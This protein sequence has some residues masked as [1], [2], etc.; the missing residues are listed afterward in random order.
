MA[1][2]DPLVSAPPM[3]SV[4]GLLDE[5]DHVGD[6]LAHPVIVADTVPMFGKEVPQADRDHA[7]TFRQRPHH[8]RPGAE[9]AERAMHADQWR[10]FSDFEIGHVVAVDTKRLH[11]D[12][13]SA[14]N[15]STISQD[16]CCGC[17]NLWCVGWG[18]ISVR[19]FGTCAASV[20]STF[21]SAPLVLPPP[22]NS[23]GVLTD[24]A[25]S[26]ENGGR[27]SRVWP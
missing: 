25:S 7:K 16:L 26:L 22:M 9:V 6:M 1:G 5:G 27:L 23:V 24:S 2:S 13:A 3:K 14:K 8:R 4:G 19:E 15:S 12:Q 17:S 20:C 18:M 10:A 21:V 11:G